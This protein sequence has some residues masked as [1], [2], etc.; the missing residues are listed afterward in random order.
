MKI[1]AELQEGTVVEEKEKISEMVQDK[2]TKIHRVYINP[3]NCR[4]APRSNRSY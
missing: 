1:C 3:S 4:T 2:V